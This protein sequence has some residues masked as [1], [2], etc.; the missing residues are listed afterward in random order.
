Y[1]KTCFTKPGNNSSHII[2]TT[3]AHVSTN[4]ILQIT[5]DAAGKRCISPQLKADRRSSFRCKENPVLLS[6]IPGWS[7]SRNMR[8]KKKCSRKRSDKRSGRGA[9]AR[10][11][12]RPR[13][14]PRGERAG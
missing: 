11:G 6:C 3:A 1:W 10:G 14:S 12:N 7:R 13:L 5:Q 8:G 4:P 2:I 9:R